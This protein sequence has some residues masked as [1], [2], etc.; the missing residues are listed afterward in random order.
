MHCIWNWYS[1]QVMETRLNFIVTLFKL[2][3]IEIKIKLPLGELM[4]P[5]IDIKRM[6]RDSIF[7]I[8]GCE[9]ASVTPNFMQFQIIIQSQLQS[10]IWQNI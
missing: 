4:H 1:D 7:D 8:H 3:I 6:T 2:G 5:L 9:K 10:G